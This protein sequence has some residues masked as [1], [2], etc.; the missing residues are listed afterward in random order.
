MQKKIYYKTRMAL[1]S[2]IIAVLFLPERAFSQQLSLVASAAEKGSGV[3]A[4]KGPVQARE[5]TGRV[6][7][8]GGVALPGVSI[9]VKGT[10]RGTVTDA[11]GSYSI[12]AASGDVLVFSYIG[13]TAREV[14]VGNE[15]TVDVALGENTKALEEVVVVGY[16]TQKRKDITG[17]VASVSAEDF[18]DIPMPNIGAG[19]T[20]RIPGLDVVTSGAGPGATN[21]IQLRGQRSFTASNDPLIIVDGSPFYGSMNDINPYDIKSVDVLKDASSTAIYGARG[22]NGVIIIT[23]KRGITGPP[24]FMIESYAGPQMIY[25]RLPYANAE[26]YAEIGR[27][28]YRAID[29]YPDTET[30]EQY[31]AVI[32]DQI[33]LEAIKRGGKGLDYQDMLFQ[34]GHQQKHQLSVMGGSEAVKYNFSGSYFNQEGIIPGEVFDRYSMRTNLDFTLSPLVTAGTSI[35]LNYSLNQRKTGPGTLNQVFQSSPLGKLYE[36]D[37]TPRFTATLDGLVLNPMADYIW[38]SYRW[39]NKRWSGLVNAYAQVK[40]LPE[41]TYRLNLGTNFNLATI[42]ESAGYYSLTRNLGTPTASIGNTVDNLKLY[43]SILTYDKTF[44]D[45]HQITVTAVHGLQS[46]RIETSGAGVSDLPYELA[47]YHNLGSASLVNAVNSNLIETDLLSYAGRVFYGYNSKY[48]LTLSIRADGAS[49]F[50]ENHKWGYFPSVALA[51]RISD[52]SFMKRTQ[53]WLSDLKL[54]LSY[55]VTGNQGISPYQTQGGLSRTVYSW[56]QAPGFGYRPT[57]LVNRDLKWETTAVYNFGLDF[58]FFTGRLQGSLDIYNTNTYDLLMFRNL[59]ITSGYEQVLQNVGRTNN[60]G[61]E[62]GLSSVNIST[63]NFSWNTDFS[64]FHNRTKIVELYNGEVDDIGN[65][66][67]IGQ[68][69][70]VYYDFKKIGIWQLNEEAEAATYGRQPGQIKVQDVDNDGAIT[71]KDRVILGSRQPDFI[72]NITNRFSYKSWDLSFQTYAR[73]GGMTSVEGFAPF[74]KKRYNKMVFDYWTPSNPT[75][76]YPRPNQLYEEGGLNGSTLTYRDASMISL[77]QLSLGYTIPKPFTE[78]LHISNARV[79]LSG[80]NLAYWTKSE[81][82]DFNMKADW[83]GDVSPYPAIRTMTVGVNLSF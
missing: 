5:V 33:E 20:G 71:D 6:T 3:K 38:D 57:E 81:L 24:K 28:A 58:G 32:F 44:R 73:W 68:P 1:L 43:E 65:R 36:D 8:N 67:F 75:N 54:R 22:A 9:A 63:P 2:L 17:S 25:G 4:A 61:I 62:L 80:E 31:D 52:E 53:S 72:A 79:F 48:M 10:S 51:Y 45:K 74:S 7:D 69:I 50:S 18:A 13:F 66:W 21:Q 27:E 42:K 37:G 16:G 26:Q 49:Q 64:F 35:L 56:N 77:R 40:I 82:R 11:D 19:L 12:S 39:D 76:E 14:T 34:N 15:A 83:A 78:K 70:Q 23:T 55:G 30:N 46:S 41:L 29:G 47:R 60:K 59:P